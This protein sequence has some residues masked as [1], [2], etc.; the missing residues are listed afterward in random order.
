MMAIRGQVFNEA[1]YTFCG[2]GAWPWRDTGGRYCQLVQ[3][4]GWTLQ[5]VPRG[6]AWHGFACW[7]GLWTHLGGGSHSDVSRLTWKQRYL[8]PW[9]RRAIRQR[10]AFIRAVQAHLD[11]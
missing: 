3:G 9:R 11:A 6:A 2:V 8:V 5:R 10:R 4:A 1:P 7:D